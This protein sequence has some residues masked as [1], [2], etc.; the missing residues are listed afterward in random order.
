MAHLYICSGIRLAASIFELKSKK[1]VPSILVFL[2]FCLLNTSLKNPPT[3][4]TPFSNATS[5]PSVCFAFFKVF[6]ELLH[7][8]E[9]MSHTLPYV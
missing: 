2:L 1:S 3:A 7:I 4:L 9:K 6:F 5:I 8:V